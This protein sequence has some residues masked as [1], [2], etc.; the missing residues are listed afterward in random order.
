MET[1][2]YKGVSISIYQD[3]SI[4]PRVDFDTIGKMVCFHGRH[5][6][7]DNHDY[8]HKDYDGW[9]EMEE[10]IRKKEKPLVILPLYLY[11]HGGI[12]MNTTGFS[13][14]W[15]SGQVGFIFATKKECK[16]EGLNLND[17]KKCLLSEVA[18]YDDYIRGDIYGFSIEDDS[19]DDTCGG[20]FE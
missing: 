11:D 17:A 13:C 18:L 16:E 19:I 3:D 20:F 15:D 2:E 5:S 12:T 8:N 4:D 14:Q 10:A 1:E 9:E 7:G 6:L